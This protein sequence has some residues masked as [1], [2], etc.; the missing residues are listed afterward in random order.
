MLRSQVQGAPAVRLAQTARWTLNALSGG[1][2]RSL[3]ASG[4]LSDQPEDN[5][6]ATLMAGLESFCA[7]LRVGSGAEP[8]E[9]A[10]MRT[11]AD[12]RRYRSAMVDRS[13]R[14]E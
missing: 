5:I 13:G 3:K 9:G 12:G 7:L 2:C 8:E 6:Y 10:N 14:Q 4:A 1:Y 11:S